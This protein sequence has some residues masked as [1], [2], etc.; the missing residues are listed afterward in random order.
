M[1]KIKESWRQNK[2]IWVLVTVLLICFGAIVVV[3]ITFFLGG[4][5]SVYGNRLKDIKK[6]PLTTE[7]KNEYIKSLEEDKLV[8]NAKID[9]KGRVIYI[10]ITFAKDTSLVEAQSK[11]AT[12]LEKFPEN[13][14][15]YYDIQFTLKCLKSENS[16]GF[17][18][19]GAHN[20]SGNGVVWNNNT[21]VKSE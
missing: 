5:K 6:Y 13:L 3:V 15:S 16:E 8:E 21:K 14:L 18:I 9:L 7:F 10:I 20:A 19:M 4:S 1:N 2:I 11:T 17:T 12:S